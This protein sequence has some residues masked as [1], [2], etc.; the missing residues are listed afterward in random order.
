[1]TSKPTTNY[2]LYGFMYEITNRAPK[3]IAGN[4]T[5][6]LIGL[7]TVQKPYQ[8]NQSSLAF[9]QFFYHSKS[10]LFLVYREAP[11]HHALERA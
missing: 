2:H 1:M 4:V 11:K 5:Q 10:S 6:I 9:S 8:L 7:H 3:R